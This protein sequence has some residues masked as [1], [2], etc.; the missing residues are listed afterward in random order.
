MF[1]GI[2]APEQ[3]M[4]GWQWLWCAEIERFASAVLAA[5][6]PESI[7]LGDVSAEDFCER[8]ERIGCPDVLVF[9]SPCQSYSIAG[10]RLG[11][12]DPRGNLA[13]I[14]LGIVDRLKPR[15]FVFENVPGLRSSW[16]GGPDV[17]V[18]ALEGRGGT[19]D[20]DESSDFAAFLGAVHGIGYS[21]AWA[22][23]DSQWRGVAQRRERLFF[24]GHLGNDWRPPA[25]VLFEPAILR[26][27]RPSRGAAR[28]GI[29]IDVAP[30]LTA[31]GRGVERAGES[32]G[33]DPVVAVP[34]EVAG[35]VSAKWRKGT[36]GPAG[37]ECYNLVAHSLRADGLD[38]SEDGTGRETPLIAFDTTQ[39]T[40]PYNRQRPKNLSP[41]LTAQG[42]APAIA[43]SSKDYGGDANNDVAPTLRS[44]GFDQSHA[45]AGVPPAVAFAIQERA[46][47]ENPNAGPDGIGVSGDGAAYTLE[48]RQVPQAVALALRGRAEG[49]TAELG[50][51]ASFALRAAQGG[52]DKPHVMV[53]TVVRRLTPI[54]CERLQ[55]FP[56]NYTRIKY[57]RRW[58][59]DSPR[60]HSL[61]NSMTVA[62][63]RF[64]LERI[65]AVD[66][67]LASVNESGM[68]RRHD[69]G[70]GMATVSRGAA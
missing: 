22:E 70:T 61:G 17:S 50:D 30:G 19:I 64:I 21:G 53:D 67:I 26:G 34:T 68:L 55:D 32:R 10:R 52:G 44:G 13:L 12:D 42:D 40:S 69:T 60:Y 29:A 57:R 31:S 38:A 4:P 33:Q 18:D 8:A 43:F 3:A 63:I 66:R 5:R 1:S 62:V 36:G 15:W 2:G 45:N 11:L 39:L 25:A 41:Q 59:A 23:L 65:E 56:D 24:V 46:T 14:A 51:D 9:G 35:A 49:G 6:H 47:S 58:A 16:S 28:Q 54:E 7:N 48:A 20:G 37:D 27:D